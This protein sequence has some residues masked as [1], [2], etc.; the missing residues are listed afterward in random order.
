MDDDR[1][2]DRATDEAPAIA[3]N[4]K[5]GPKESP[6]QVRPSGKEAMADKPENWDAQDEALDE[7]FP[8]SDPP[9]NYRAFDDGLGSSSCR[10]ASS[11][12]LR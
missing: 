12:S 10:G 1:T 6:V 5:P 7:T 4:K 2:K 8:A 9:T 11:V 3:G